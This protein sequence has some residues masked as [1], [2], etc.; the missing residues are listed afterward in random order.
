M[1][2]EKNSISFKF[3]LDN[4][5]INERQSMSSDTQDFRV[6]EIEAMCPNGEIAWLFYL[7]E[8]NKPWFKV[9][10][11]RPNGPNERVCVD[12]QKS[13]QADRKIRWVDGLMT[14]KIVRNDRPNFSFRS[15]T[16]LSFIEITG[17]DHRVS[18]N[19]VVE[20]KSAP[21]ELVEGLLK[22]LRSQVLR[23]KI[24]N[25][26]VLVGVSPH[27]YTLDEL[28]SASAILQKKGYGV[29]WET[30]NALDGNF[31]IDITDWIMKNM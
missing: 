23:G 2:A 1:S 31:T 28:N 8:T 16:G 5:D 17:Y 15:E 13:R 24:I 19:Q 9:T 12:L 29:Q 20:T 11:E 30:F 26:R 22:E 14:W 3:F 6:E 27:I 25:G 4:R 18:K 7:R 21:E 10:L